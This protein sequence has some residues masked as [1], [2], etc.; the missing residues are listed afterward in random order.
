[1]AIVKYK[2]EIKD[3]GA[4][5][6]YRELYGI[7][8]IKER[9]YRSMAAGLREV[10]ARTL[11]ILQT[12]PPP[13]RHP[14]RWRSI[15]QRKAVM[16]WLREQGYVGAPRDEEGNVLESTG[17]IR[18]HKMSQAWKVEQVPGKS[19]GEI[20]QIVIEN[21]HKARN[22][23]GQEVYPF[24]FVHGTFTDSTYQQ[25]FHVDTGWRSL[26]VVVSDAQDAAIRAVR[27][28]IVKGEENAKKGR[29]R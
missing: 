2:I 5:K 27:S 26:P 21:R 7:R 24:Q 6:A 22:A 15:K 13:A 3:R 9:L 18:T 20:S 17:Y 23:V 10:R 19:A 14:L 4:L 8:R 25:P 1:M 11:A 12:E 29:R 28:T 16:A